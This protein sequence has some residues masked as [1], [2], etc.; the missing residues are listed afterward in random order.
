MRTIA[1]WLLFISQ[2]LFTL[3]AQSYTFSGII[4]N[5][6][7]K[8]M[9]G[10]QV[11]LSV[12][13]SLSAMAL[14]DE[15]GHFRI[16]GLKEGAYELRLFFLGYNAQEQILRVENRDVRKDFLLTPEKT[17]VLDEVMVTG[18]RNDQVNRT[19]TGEIFYLSEKAKNMK[20]PFRALQEIPRLYSDVANRKVQLE[21]GAQPLIL[22]NGN[23]YNS[24][25]ATL[26]P[27]E[28]E[29]V[30]IIDVV[31]ARYLKD[32]YQKILNIKLK[33]KTQPFIFLEGATRHDVPFRKGLGVGYFEVGNS[34][35]ALYG[36]ASVDYLYDDRSEQEQRQLNTGYSKWTKGE[37]RLDGTS[38]LGELQ[39]R[40]MCTD[41]DYIVAHMYGNKKINK[42]KGW[43][44]GLLTDGIP[45]EFDYSS[46]NKD[47]SYIFTAS[48]FHKHTFAKNHILETT[49]AFN[50]NHNEND[51]NR[52]ESYLDWSYLNTYLYKNDRNSGRF[53]V[54]YNVDFA[55]GGSL[56]VGNQTRFTSDRIRQVSIGMPTF[57]HEKWTKG[58][59]RL[60]GTSYL[61]ELQ[62]RWMC[63][64]KDYI[65]AHMYGNKKINKK[66]GWGDGLLTDGIPQEF[67]YSSFNKDQS[68]IFTASLF[69]KHT[70]AKNHI[71]ETTLAFNKNHNENDG[72]RSESYLDWSYLNTYL[73]KNDR[74]SG[75]FDVDYNVDFANGGSLNVGNQTRFTSDRIRQVSIGMPTF[76]HEKWEE[77]LYADYS[78]SIKRF[79]YML[80]AGLEGIWLKAGEASNHYFKPRISLSGNYDFSDHLSTRLG[81]TLTNTAPT[82][83]ELN[84]YNMSTDSLVKTQGNPYLLP[85]QNHKLNLSLTFNTKGFYLTPSVSYRISTDLVES[86]GFSEE[87]I[88]IS[89]YRN[90]GKYKN[91]RIGGSLSY[92]I[93]NLGRIGV[94]A[95]HVVDY[96][97][98]EDPRKGFSTSL[99]FN[100]N[101]KKWYLGADILYNNYT[102]TPISRVKYHS[103]S[104]SMVQ[105]SYN[106]TDYFYISVAMENCLVTYRT[107]MEL[108]S[109]SYENYSDQRKI[110][111]SFRPWILLR[112]TFRKNKSKAM[113]ERKNV[114]SIEEGIKL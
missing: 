49:L 41:K 39:F 114:Y 12:E 2:G 60:D 62:F 108:R 45:Q 98:N 4:T 20:D 100:A 53:D 26:D 104:F 90:S 88:Y 1:F 89:S 19:A 86:Y 24:G 40:W 44:D 51:G 15:K 67:D 3:S 5:E 50:K 109:G 22:I 7:R 112:Y 75:R 23:R 52:S 13:D 87:D 63:T 106:F 27:R 33:K 80:S 56:N 85:S 58:E 110:S 82:E 65:V 32:G 103:P 76:R 64:D 8:M 66:K 74:N 9:D 48:L 28:I 37:E 31:K 102:Y 11:I 61:G 36:R 97:E 107:S 21:D 18:N 101:Y 57:R 111:A 14:T 43:G 25:I 68:Y 77:Y 30:E 16:D 46:F 72:N 94:N 96:Y 55:N 47:Q 54:D 92:R 79:S 35:Y 69:H 81:Y 59:E 42:K 6:K 91:L 84:P 95:Y 70:F 38:Y 17:V 113:K 83:S 93:G 71:L 73:Y 29:S 10:V 34:R 99:Y 78:Q 105:V